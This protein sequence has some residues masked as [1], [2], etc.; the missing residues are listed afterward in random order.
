VTKL[1]LC[2]D[3]C[4]DASLSEYSRVAPLSLPRGLVARAVFS[5]H[6]SVEE[7]IARIVERD[8]RYRIEAYEFVREASEKALAMKSP[9]VESPIRPHVSVKELLEVLRVFA[10]LRFEKE[11]KRR[12][13]EWS[14]KSCEDF[15]EIVF[16][17]VDVGL[18]GKQPS[19]RKEDFQGG[20]NFDEAFPEI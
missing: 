8:P 2:E 3:C 18:L 10:L 4:R 11:A 15:G 5:T 12:L 1:D 19:D 16:N 17:L 13:N 20:Y 9:V 6:E 7:I 14:V